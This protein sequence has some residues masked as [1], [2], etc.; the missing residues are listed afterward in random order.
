MMTNYSRKHKLR[1][2]TEKH[3][4]VLFLK[5]I[6]QFEKLLSWFPNTMK[7]RFWVEKPPK[8]VWCGISCHSIVL[9][10]KKI[11]IY[12]VKSHILSFT[13]HRAH[14]L[15]LMSCKV[16]AFSLSYI[17]RL[18]YSNCVFSNK[19]NTPHRNA[20]TYP[21]T[22]MNTHVQ[23]VQQPFLVNCHYNH[24]NSPSF[25]PTHTFPGIS[26]QWMENTRLLFRSDSSAIRII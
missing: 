20:H 26:R 15:S 5:G 25:P 16:S 4:Q 2:H 3:L 10:E 8:A 19:R 24:H 11:I 22:Q 21:N 23:R 14:V 12:P 13:H 17:L 6:T 18:V 1:S 7:G 9:K